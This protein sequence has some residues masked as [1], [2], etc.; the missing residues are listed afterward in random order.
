ML[1]DIARAYAAGRLLL[2][3]TTNLDA[4]MPV[5]WNI[6]AIAGSGHPRALDT[7]PPHPAG[8]LRHSRRLPAGACSTSRWTA[9]P[10][11][12]CMSTAAPS[13]RSSSIPAASHGSAA[14]RLASG[15]AVRTGRACVI[16]NG[17]LD[18]EWAAVERRTLG[19]AGRAIATMITP[20]GFNDVVRIYAT[21]GA[22]ASTTIWPTSAATSPCSCRRRST[23][24]TCAPLF[25]YGYQRALRGYDWVKR[26]PII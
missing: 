6:G 3:A 26:P 2:I 19:I 11:R 17:R 15:G 1:A 12:R 8:L 23:R 7:D 14:A 18:P 16:R 9:S 22:T 5:I 13:P 24:P 20:A 10:T 25:D 4:Q 21:T